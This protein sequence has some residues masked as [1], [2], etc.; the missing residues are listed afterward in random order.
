MPASVP[1]GR[2]D[3][4]RLKM[5]AEWERFLV[6]RSNSHV[7]RMWYLNLKKR[8]M[9]AHSESFNATETERFECLWPCNDSH[10]SWILTTPPHAVNQQKAASAH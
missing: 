10:L 5:L 3:V 6:L 2:D 4:N 9:D 8:A 7:R 1:D